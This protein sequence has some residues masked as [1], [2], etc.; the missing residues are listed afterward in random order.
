VY[1]VRRQGPDT[2][3]VEALW[4]TLIRPPSVGG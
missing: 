4:Q 3:G 1:A 2:P